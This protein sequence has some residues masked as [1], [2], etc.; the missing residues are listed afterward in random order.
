MR[1][2]DRSVPPFRRSKLRIEYRSRFDPNGLF[3]ALSRVRE[4]NPQSVRT[5]AHGKS[6]GSARNSTAG[7]GRG[8]GDSEGGS[9]GC[10]AE[11]G[12]ISVSIDGCRA[13]VAT[14]PSYIRRQR[15]ADAVDKAG[16]RYVESR[17]RGNSG[18]RG[19][20]ADVDSAG[21]CR[22]GDKHVCCSGDA[23]R[24]CINND[25]T[26]PAS[27]DHS[28][29][30]DGDN[31]GCAGGDGP[32]GRAGHIGG[33]PAI[34]GAGRAEVHAV[35]FSQKRCAGTDDDGFDGAF[36][37]PEAGAGTAQQDEGDKRKQAS[38]VK[39]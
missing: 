2:I 34:G 9:S 36:G 10:G 31:G 38:Y 37:N 22:G 5:L 20:V 25:G 33:A 29:A 15:C 3:G 6:S 21:Q 12:D 27:R 26:L 28:G 11:Y 17:R 35:A 32:R 39:P 4:Q 19:R 14:T 1:P 8:G 7:C 13:G 30:G 23:T 18:G 16:R 24:G